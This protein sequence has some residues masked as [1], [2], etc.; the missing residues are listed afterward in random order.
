[1]ERYSLYNSRRWVTVSPKAYL[2]RRSRL[3]TSPHDALA[4][5]NLS[6]EDTQ[7]LADVQAPTLK[8]FARQVKVRLLL[9]HA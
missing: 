9:N 1:M 3:L 4:E 7:I 6:P 2:A 8:E 5:M